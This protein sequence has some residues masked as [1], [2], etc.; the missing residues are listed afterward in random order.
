MQIDH[1]S[2]KEKGI[3][4]NMHISS[5][6]EFSRQLITPKF[7]LE[8][9]RSVQILETSQVFPSQNHVL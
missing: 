1:R 3:V 6:K 7:D 4:I 8:F 9:V 2:T 5:H